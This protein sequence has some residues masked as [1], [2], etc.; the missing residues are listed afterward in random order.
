MNLVVISQDQFNLLNALIKNRVTFLVIGGQAIKAYDSTRETFDL[1]VLLGCSKGN[2]I[3]VHKSLNSKLINTTD[4]SSFLDALSKPGKRIPYP[5]IANKIADLLT[6]IDGVDLASY[7]ASS[8][9]A[10]F[11]G[12]IARI[13]SIPHLIKM[14]EI[15]LG[16]AE[17]KQLRAREEADI[18]RLKKLL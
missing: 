12:L 5:G 13:P 7:I 1:D 16:L 18:A 8:T 3:R 2:A 14:K 6:S 17:N 9:E 4:N 11:G 10:S 15:S